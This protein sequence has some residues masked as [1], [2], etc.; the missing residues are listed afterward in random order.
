MDDVQTA[1]AEA[2]RARELAAIPFPGMGILP[3]DVNRAEWMLGAARRAGGEPERAE[4]HLAEALELCRRLNMVVHEAGILI[5]IARLRMMTG[6][7][8]EAQR[9]ADEALVISERC[10]YVLQGADA[11]LALAQIAKHR[12]D[13]S[14]ARDHAADALRLATCDGPPDYTYKVTYDKAKAMLALL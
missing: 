9:V 10:E 7:W 14:A 5:A 11:H 13:S 2:T 4:I 8:D 3:R 12:R 6:D 1:V